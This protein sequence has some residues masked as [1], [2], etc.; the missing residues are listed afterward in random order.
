MKTCKD[1]SANKSV[2]LPMAP[3]TSCADSDNKSP[4][5]SPR[6]DQAFVAGSVEGPS[7]RIPQVS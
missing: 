1:N 3:L 4:L 2:L 7:G 5:S 6:L